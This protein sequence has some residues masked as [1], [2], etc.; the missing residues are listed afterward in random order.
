MSR[1]SSSLSE[2]FDEESSQS[3]EGD[4]AEEYEYLQSPDLEQWIQFSQQLSPEEFQQFI[5]LDDFYAFRNAVEESN[6]EVARFL[7][8]KIDPQRLQEMIAADDFRVLRIGRDGEEFYTRD[9]AYIKRIAAQKISPEGLVAMLVNGDGTVNYGELIAM[10]DYQVVR[11]A[12]DKMLPEI[13]PQPLAAKLLELSLEY[14]GV[15]GMNSSVVKIVLDKIAPVNMA[16]EDFC[17]RIFINSILHGNVDVARSMLRQDPMPA[18]LRGLITEHNYELVQAAVANNIDEDI[19][20]ALLQ[21]IPPLT[22]R[23]MIDNILPALRDPIEQCRVRMLAF[24]VPRLPLNRDR[25]SVV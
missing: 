2:E 18:N 12:L 9:H 19:A 6:I 22:D 20:S 17:V 7:F 24:I 25:K 5:S 15:Y 14:A 21:E 10:N 8:D 3:S 11:M 4:F 13:V 16:S 1:S 23:Q